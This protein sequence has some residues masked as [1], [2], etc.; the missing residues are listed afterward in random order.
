MMII[1][2]FRGE[3]AFLS[4]FHKSPVSYEGLVYPCV[5]N[6]FQAQKCADTEGKVKYILQNNP[7]RAKMMG[8][9]EKLPPDWDTRSVE[10]MEK[11]LRAKFSDPTL[12]AALAAGA[13]GAV[14]KSADY[15]E[16]IASIRTV[17]SGET[18]I[19]PEVRQLM[20]TDPPLP[21]LSKR[22][23]EILES[24][25]KGLTNVDIANQLGIGVPMV[26]EH[27][28]ALLQKIGAANRSEAVAI[29][30]RKYLL[31]S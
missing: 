24:I 15:S 8:K 29:A 13:S 7:V 2:E 18:A 9:K 11:L 27:V 12:S 14:L 3:Y 22:Q 23:R 4:N 30:M 19:S 20:E 16:L 28:N 5:E 26:K 31:K 6:A 17:A 25:T 10:I 1:N 21:E